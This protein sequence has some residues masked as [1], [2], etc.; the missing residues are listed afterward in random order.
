MNLLSDGGSPIP[1]FDRA[2]FDSHHT[3]T[4]V[5]GGG[6]GGKA[7]G[8]I[9]IRDTLQGLRRLETFQ[10]VDLAIPRLTVLGTDLFDRFMERN[11]LYSVAL[12]DAPDQRIAHA[13]QKGEFPSAHLGD[14]RGLIENVHTPLAVRSS[15]LLEDALNRPFAGVY[16][17]KMI[18]NN[19]PDPSARFQGLVEAVKLVYAST[20]FRNAKSYRRATG[21]GSEVEK[22]AVI[23]QE[24]LGER[25]GDRFYPDLSLVARSY[26]YYPMGRA[27]PEQGVVSLALGLGKTI[28]DGGV[29]W[30]Y[31]P[32]YPKAPPPFGSPQQIFRETQNRFWA[33]NMGA[34]PSYDPIAETEYLQEGD[35]GDAEYDGTLEKLVST[36]DSQGDRFMPGMGRKGP[37]VLDFSPLLT[38]NL[39][40]VNE[41]VKAILAACEETLGAEVEVEMAMAVPSSG[42][43]KARLGFLQV[44][45]MLAPEETVEVSV[46]ELGS[47][48]M[49]VSSA[50]T[51]GN[52]V[53]DNI[54]DVVYT[55]PE[56]F[57]AKHTRAV[58]SEIDKV[59]RALVAEGRPYVLIGFGRWG[60][61]DPWLGI[62]VAWGMV[63]G[64]KAIVEATLPTMNV[65]PSQGSH[66][67]HNLTSLQVSYFMVS[68]VRDEDRIDWDWLEGLEAVVEGDLVRHVRTRV[69]LRARVDGRIGRG[70]VER[71]PES[72]SQSSEPTS[73]RSDGEGKTSA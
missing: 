23:I 49:L 36:Y 62:P 8:L 2:F 44:R 17:T 5:G 29:C 15:S 1:H 4:R 41:M 47:S 31:C 3:F 22:M 12:S 27:R 20:F 59:N 32:A 28:V 40:P 25:H 39:I 38:L 66:F 43:E 67:F 58:A 53:I 19:Q 61:S 48:S 6:L 37:R 42:G 7:E 14:L 9:R 33:V 71:S 52:G 65:E 55:R 72:P 73:G 45:P 13:F 10:D 51:M 64:A 30:S 70:V 34:P 11:H 16:E 24:V 60:S 50:R 46:E 68:H 35:L 18:P 26:N 54:Y 21:E 56:A 57:E 69:P 63:S